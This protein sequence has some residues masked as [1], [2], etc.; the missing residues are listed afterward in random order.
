[1]K[2]IFFRVCLRQRSAAYCATFWVVADIVR[3]RAVPRIAQ[4]L[5]VR[6]LVSCWYEL[7]VWDLFGGSFWGGCLSQCSPRAS[8]GTP[9]EGCRSPS[10]HGVPHDLHSP[11]VEGPCTFSPSSFV[12]R[13]SCLGG[14]LSPGGSH[15]SARPDG[16]LSL[17]ILV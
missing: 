5:H 4:D 11:V 9:I 2:N 6:P 1:M 16:P 13:G 14:F 12:L 7:Q 3:T 10:P 17:P 15:G 8:V